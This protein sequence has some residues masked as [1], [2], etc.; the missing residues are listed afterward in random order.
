MTDIYENHI[1]IIR[2][3]GTINFHIASQTLRREIFKLVIH[4]ECH[5][6]GIRGKVLI[7][8]QHVKVS[9]VEKVEFLWLLHTE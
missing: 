5:H 4:C 9:L 8:L 1:A 2:E 3:I 7:G 6:G